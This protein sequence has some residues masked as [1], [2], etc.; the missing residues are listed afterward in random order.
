MTLDYYYDLISAP[1][2]GPMMVAKAIGVDLNLKEINLLKGEQMSEAFLAMNPEH[3]VPTLKD[4]E[5]V[6]WESKAIIGYLMGQYAKDDA[7]YPRGAAERAR[8]DQA[9]YFDMALHQSFRNYAHPVIKEGASPSASALRKLD[10]HLGVLDT[11]LGAPGPYVTGPRPCVADYTL[12][13]ALETYRAL[14]IP[15]APHPRIVAFLARCQ[16]EMVAYDEIC[17]R[18]AMGMADK[19]KARFEK[20]G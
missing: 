12:V 4:G 2:R 6:L 15:L 18:G 5:F 14:G 17:L 20:T 9:L 1:C 19:F 3:V 11:R 10:K 13:C 16:S 7:L 8:V